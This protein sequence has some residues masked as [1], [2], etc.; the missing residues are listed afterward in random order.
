MGTTI[1][2]VSNRNFGSMQKVSRKQ[3][4]LLM[5]AMDGCDACARMKV[6][7]AQFARDWDDGRVG[8]VEA[9]SLPVLERT[10]GI[11]YFPAF[12]L[13]RNGKP[14]RVSAEV[15]DLNDLEDFVRR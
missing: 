11:E 4:V 3:P 9:D 14:V 8:F 1:Q 2:R 10:L 5:F 13:Y 15:D 6:V 12:A 7:V